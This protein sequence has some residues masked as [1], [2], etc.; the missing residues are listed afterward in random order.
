MII[1]KYVYAARVFKSIK[2]NVYR[3][4]S[5]AFYSVQPLP[6]KM[7]ENLYYRFVSVYFSR[8]SILHSDGDAPAPSHYE[9]CKFKQLSE[10]LQMTNDVEQ[11]S[12]GYVSLN[13]I[14]LISCLRR[15]FT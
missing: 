5:I 14:V 11:R 10:S 7:P 1:K 4:L 3:V 2:I 12:V 8:F 13:V 6:L 9:L 15:I